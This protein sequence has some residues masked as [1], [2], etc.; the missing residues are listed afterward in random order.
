MTKFKELDKRSAYE[1]EQDILKS[2][3]GINKINEVYN[4][5]IDNNISYLKLSRI[6]F[7][8]WIR[9]NFIAF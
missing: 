3:G 5:I 2:W 8:N 7:T 6:F 4:K 1:V 9:I